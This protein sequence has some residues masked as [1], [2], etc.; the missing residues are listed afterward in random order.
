[1]KTIELLKHAKKG[2]TNFWKVFVNGPELTVTWGMVGGKTQTKTRI[3]DQGKQK[4]SLEDQALF[5]AKNMV[6][7]KV[8]A[9]YAINKENSNI[10]LESE[11]DIDEI[12]QAMLAYPWDPTKQC[13]GRKAFLQPKLDGL[14]CI[15][16]THTGALWSRTRKPFLGLDHITE[17]I[18][19]FRGGARFLDGEIY[20]HGMGFQEITSIARRT[21]TIDLEASRR[22]EF[23]VFDCVG[24]GNF[25]ERWS[26]L[27]KW[28]ENG[29]VR[30]VKTAQTTLNPE[31]ITAAHAGYVDLGYEGIII[32][33]DEPYVHSRSKSLLKVKSFDQEEFEVVKLIKQDFSNTCGSVVVK[34]GNKTFQATP[35]CTIRQKE[36]MWENRE[37]YSSKGWVATVKF[38]GYSTDGIPRFPV[39]LGFRH[40]HDC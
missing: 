33:L 9:G 28:G 1:M 3:Y 29:P 39:A 36:E 22:L 16:D 12:P 27:E 40:P 26:M 23:H 24:E 4:R 35:A 38:F 15:A 7:S 30:L 25:S 5:E 18:L 14:R 10:H 32:R 8:R 31:I 21:K 2:G 6:K 19:S 37:E 13:D 17:T 20:T 34:I 11:N